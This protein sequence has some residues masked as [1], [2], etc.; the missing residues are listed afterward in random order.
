MFQ[1]IEMLFLVLSTNAICMNHDPDENL[2]YFEMVAVI[3]PNQAIF[4]IFSI[5]RAFHQQP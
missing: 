1:L 2:T 4:T 3:W 5:I